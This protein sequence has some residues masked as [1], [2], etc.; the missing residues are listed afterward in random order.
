MEL[1]R[2]DRNRCDHGQFDG[3]HTALAAGGAL[4]TDQSYS[5]VQTMGGMMQGGLVGGQ[6]IY[7][8][9]DLETWRPDPNLETQLQ[10]AMQT[11]QAEDGAEVYVSIILGGYRVLAGTKRA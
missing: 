8:V 4:G 3:W 2:G 1:D 5:L 6:L 10:S 7:P 9:V 11:A